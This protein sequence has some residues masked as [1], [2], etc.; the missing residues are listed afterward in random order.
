MEAFTC[1]L[2]ETDLEYGGVKATVVRNLEVIEIG[3]Y[4]F[5]LGEYNYM[6][7]SKE[8]RHFCKEGISD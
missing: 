7:M 6:I 1:L 4:R 8:A 5:G 3:D 2:G